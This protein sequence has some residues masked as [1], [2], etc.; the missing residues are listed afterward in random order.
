VIS[1]ILTTVELTD[2][3]FKVADANS[4]VGN[5]GRLLPDDVIVLVAATPSAKLSQLGRHRRL[6]THNITSYI[7]HIGL[8]K[9]AINQTL[10]I[11]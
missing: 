9:L 6:P 5:G 10:A 1:S 8:G 11:L 2:A 7:T 3:G 4:H